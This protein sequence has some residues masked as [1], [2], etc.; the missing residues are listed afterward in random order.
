[1]RR[2]FNRRWAAAAAA[3]ALT[4]S[5]LVATAPPAS[6]RDA[7]PIPPEVNLN[8]CP[9][10][11]ELPKGADP[12]FW[13][14]TVV[15]ITGGRLQFGTIDQKIDKPIALTYAN[16]FDP[17]TL[18]QSFVFRPL[19]GE[20]LKVAGGVLGI[21]GTDVLPFLE[22]YAQAQLARDPE[23]SPVDDP[24]VAYR[25]HMKIKNINPLLGDTCYVGSDSD[26]ITLN[27]TF[28][29]TNPPPPNKPITGRGI[30]PHPDD[31]TVFTSTV[32]DNA[33]SVPKSTGCG[34]WGLLNGIAD[35][36]AGLP[37][38]AG[39]NTAV[40]ETMAKFRGYSEPTAINSLTK[41]R[42]AQAKIEAKVE[43][44]R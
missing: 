31:P 24:N 27:L 42:A 10:L 32:V 13:L 35:F 9:T 43:Q 19:K 26:P 22:L 34:P 6:A 38:K 5:A 4:A 11:S 8:D 33:F 7:A 18:E 1:M 36:R 17:V 14:C 29:T 30:E 44:A 20:P 12:N 25:M 39:T 3:A 37:A 41:L 16:G 40:F 2:P 21:P 28:G 15:V 23:V